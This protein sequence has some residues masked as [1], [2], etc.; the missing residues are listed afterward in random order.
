MLFGAHKTT[1]ELLNTR[2]MATS[3]DKLAN[4]ISVL[5]EHFHFDNDQAK[6]LLA[7]KGLLPKKLMPKKTDVK[8]KF[9]SKKAEELAIKYHIVPDANGSGRDGR[10]TLSDVEKH[11]AKPVNSKLLIS[12]NALNLAND[13]GINLSGKSGSGQNGRILLKDVQ[14]WIDEENPEDE[15]K[16]DITP[17]A[18]AEARD[19]N[20]SD[21]ELATIKGT[22]QN[23]RILK[24]DIKKYVTES[25]KSDTSS[26]SDSSDSES[27]DED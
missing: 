14:G 1:C 24:D 8:S 6:E 9:A 15:N 17:S 23:G 16:I 20:I 19:N 4:I 25:E 3:A 11:M 22:G 2:K 26:N 13:R 18:A 27:D 7:E 10:W 21:K 12:P 5:S